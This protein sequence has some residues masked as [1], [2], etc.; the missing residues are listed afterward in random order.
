MEKINKSTRYIIGLWLNRKD[1]KSLCKVSKK[2]C[3]IFYDNEFWLYKLR[4]RY[5]IYNIENVKNYK[6]EC[7]ILEKTGKLFYKL[8]GHFGHVKPVHPELYTYFDD[9][10][11]HHTHKKYIGEKVRDFIV[12][13]TQIEY[14]DENFK[15]FVYSISKDKSWFSKKNVKKLHYFNIFSTKNDKLYYNVLGVGHSLLFNKPRHVSYNNLNIYIT[16]SDGCVYS[17]VMI[18]TKLPEN[19]DP[20]DTKNYTEYFIIA[21]NVNKFISNYSEKYIIDV[22]DYLYIEK[23]G[24]FMKIDKIKSVDNNSHFLYYV[25]ENNNLYFLDLH[26]L[27]REP[28]FLHSNVKFIS[29]SAEFYVFIN[30]INELWYSNCNNKYKFKLSNNVKKAKCAANVVAFTEYY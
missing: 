11:I 29:C 8:I 27:D 6:L 15:N 16:S 28:K 21:K 17:D 14:V 7:E 20:H 30:N 10:I 26:T 13:S 5:G 9:E 22:D 25:D 19:L 12:C 4:T 2:W 23:N 24:Y 3:K 18:T 1:W